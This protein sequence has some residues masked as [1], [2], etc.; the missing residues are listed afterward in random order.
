M[1]GATQSILTWSTELMSNYKQA[2]VMAPDASFEALQTDSGDALLFSIGTD[3]VCY[4]TQETRAAAVG[5]RRIAFSAR[6]G[7]RPVKLVAVAQN[8]GTGKIDIALVLGGQPHDDLYLSLGNSSKDVS[9]V[10]EPTFTAVP[11]DATAGPTTVTIND[12]FISQASDGEY[13][14]ADILRDPSDSSPLISRY[15]IDPTSRLTGKAWNAHDV[16]GDLRASN[17]RSTI[18]RRPGDRVDGIYTVGEI[19]G[20]GQLIFQPLYNPF[21]PQEAANPVALTGPAGVIGTALCAVAAQADATDLY[22]AYGQTL[23]MFPAEAQQQGATGTQLLDLPVLRGVRHLFGAA[24]DTRLIL[25]GLNQA[26]QVFYTTCAVADRH[27]PTAWSVPLPIVT[28]AE[29]ISPYLNRSNDGNSYFVHTGSNELSRLTQAPDTTAWKSEKVLLPAPTTMKAVKNTSYTTRVQVTDQDKKPLP[30]ATVEVSCSRRTSVYINGLYYVLDSVPTPVVADA[31]GSVNIIEWVESLNGTPLHIVGPDGQNLA[32]NP[33]DKPFAKA[34]SLSTADALRAATIPGTAQAASRALVSSDASDAD[35]DTAATALGQLGTIYQ[36][37]P[38]DGSVLPPPTTPTA[39][40]TPALTTTARSAGNVR[41]AALHSVSA[42]AGHAPHPDLVLGGGLS[43]ITVAAGDLWDW[44]VAE[45][46][47]VV[48]I[49]HDAETSLWHFV[50]QIAGE[51]YGFVLDAADKVVGA[52]LTIYNAIKTAIEDLIA[53]L[54][55]L[56]EWDSFVRT[57]DVCQKFLLMSLQQVATGTETLKADLNAQLEAARTK[58]DDWADIKSDGWQPGVANSSSSVGFMGTV[59]EV[60]DILTAPAMF[61]YHHVSD[62][63]AGAQS[64]GPVDGTGAPDVLQIVLDALDNADDVVVGALGRVKTELIDGGA[65]TNLSL[66]ETLQKLAAI[67]VD[68]FLEG[69]ETLIDALLD[70]LVAVIEAGIEDLSTPIWIPVVSD[71]LEDFGVTIDFSILD[72]LLMV[73]AIPATLSYKIANG[74]A[75]FA[76]GDISDQILAANTPA[77]LKAAL[78]GGG[79]AVRSVPMLLGASNTTATSAADPQATLYY[80]IYVAGNIVAGIGSIIGAILS[81]GLL[82]GEEEGA[83][84]QR[85]V[86]AAGLVTA[87]T[88]SIAGYVDGPDPISDTEVAALAQSVTYIGVAAKI[89]S[90]LASRNA[91]GTSISTDDAEK[92]GA[93]IDA[94]VGFIALTPA[95]YHFQELAGASAGAPRPSAIVSETATIVSSIGS[96]SAFFAVIDKDPES[97]AILA[98]TTGVLGLL[99]GGLRFAVSAI[100]PHSSTS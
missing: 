91:F 26:D 50:A 47:Y 71:I 40:P 98:A 70:L 23:Y 96:I 65:L 81:P 55:F 30:G 94:I 53:F 44:L 5:W 51:V 32:V 27:D 87:V 72:V 95:V 14:V 35:L 22:V 76:P 17:V 39:T 93:G 25:W 33:M 62:N 64:A 86:I 45:S 19:A 52:I 66:G 3:A 21:R 6:L 74:T 82:M 97:K 73:G 28:G 89:V 2:E 46:D 20:H 61:L 37:M 41:V 34:A 12:V 18:G 84:W 1:S 11:F 83:S 100:N 77:E 36:T 13:I 31:I 16:A 67:V 54:E 9:W 56:F 8:A 43:F 4:L 49:L 85:A 57:K 88:D 90:A 42:G 24:T 59:A 58:V 29:Q 78:E 60:G 99:Y 92:A 69:T 15:Y 10:D 75:P 79:T 38:I 80:D 63:I 48:H 68:A 7:D